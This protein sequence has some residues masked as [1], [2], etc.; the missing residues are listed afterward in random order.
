MPYRVLP[1]MLALSLLSSP[2]RTRAQEPDTVRSVDIQAVTVNSTFSRQEKLGSS[3]S[4][5]IADKAFIREYFTGNLVQTLGNIPGVRSMDIGSGFSKPVIRGMGFNRIAVLENGIKQEG[6]QWGADHGLEI[7]AFNAER[8]VVRKGPASLMYGSDAMGGTIEITPLPPPAEDMFFGEAVV[9]GRS[10][11]GTLAASVMLALKRNRWYTRLRYTGQNFGDYRVPT[12]TIVYLT[13]KLP[14]HGNRLKN[15]ARRERDVSLWTE[16]RRNGY[17][18]SFSVSNAYQKVGFF[19]GAHGIP[20]ASRLENDGSRRD[21]GLPYS[22]VNHLKATTRQQYSWRSWSASLDLGYQNNR[23]T[24]MSEFHTHYGNQSRPV[25]NPDRELF[26]SLNTF[27]ASARLRY[28]GTGGWEHTA[29]VDV[30][31]QHNGIGGYSFLLPRYDRAISGVYWIASWTVTE[32]L[33][34]TGGLRYDHGRVDISAYRDSYLADYLQTN[35]YDA[36]TIARYEWRSYAVDKRFGDLSGGAGLVWNPGRGHLVKANIGR[37]FRLPGANELASNGVHHGT[38]RHEQGDAALASERGWQF[39][40]E[41]G[42]EMGRFSAAVSPFASRYTNYIYL[43]PTG[44]WSLLP[45]AGQVY[46]Y[47][48]AR[49]VLAG[50]EVSLA[51]SLPFGFG[52]SFAGEYVYTYN[53]DEDIP[54]AFSPP[55]T[56]RNTVSWTGGRYGVHIETESLARQDRV[57]RNE[58]P[59]PGT[60]LFHAGFS[61]DIPLGN[62]VVEVTLR[63]RNIFDRKYYNHL[64]FYRHIEIPEPGR[65]IQLMIK[66]PFKTR[67]K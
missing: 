64:S 35:G 23:R 34:L 3:L 50:T 57:A 16:H 46:R 21:I 39:D 54:L 36:E 24:E 53:L 47:T 5:D 37:S 30:Q 27:S 2:L 59:T 33:T 15:T 22:T 10:V 51:V 55:A 41:Y 61:A 65:N 8:V 58:S 60:N 13:Q 62:T 28:F 12:D 29:G 14:V 32:A 6:Q 44:E 42:Y 43:R 67:T 48:G 4:V 40:M 7:D 17:Y 45:H 18:T 63:L 52:Y 56:M 1:A 49:A 20:D 11:N 26:F 38:F 25:K 9:M 66:V 19:P 31:Y